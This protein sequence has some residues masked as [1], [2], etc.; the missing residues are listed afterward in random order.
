MDGL[1]AL[2]S[3]ANKKKSPSDNFKEKNTSKTLKDF[4]PTKK[5]KEYEVWYVEQDLSLFFKEIVTKL[6]T[7]N[8]AFM[9]KVL[10]E[11][12]KDRVEAISNLTGKSEQEILELI[13]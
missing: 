7:K 10:T 6:E 2:S 13:K 1:D 9:E 11:F 12:V 5:K 4:A 8:N 3:L